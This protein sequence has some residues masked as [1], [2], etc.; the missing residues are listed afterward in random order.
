MS[1]RWRQVEG[2]HHRL[3]VEEERQKSVVL[4]LGHRPAVADSTASTFLCRPRS[5]R[6]RRK[7][8]VRSVGSIERTLEHSPVC[9]RPQMGLPVQLDNLRYIHSPLLC[10]RLS[11]HLFHLRILHDSCCCDRHDLRSRGG[12]RNPHRDHHVLS[13]RQFGAASL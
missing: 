5:L 8:P 9:L 12:R 7:G 2:V 1:H 4:R 6:T 10:Q 3:G 13:R 11:R